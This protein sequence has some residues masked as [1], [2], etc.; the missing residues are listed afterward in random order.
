MLILLLMARRLFRH[1]AELDSCWHCSI[2]GDSAL[3]PPAIQSP[4]N[5]FADSIRWMLL[6]E[7]PTIAFD[8]HRRAQNVLIDIFV[9]GLS[10]PL[11]L[12]P[13]VRKLISSGGPSDASSATFGCVLHHYYFLFFSSLLFFG[14]IS[15]RASEC[16]LSSMSRHRHG[17][18][19]LHISDGASR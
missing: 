3:I 6:N 7:S 19:C 8:Y 18:Q 15:E 11:S 2:S 4:S 13:C 1:A 12:P 9:F 16:K 5:L 17:Q 10:H 14:I